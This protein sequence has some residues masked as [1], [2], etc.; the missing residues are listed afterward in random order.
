M[1]VGE[2]MGQQWGTMGKHGSKQE[3]GGGRS[4]FV[5]RYL[6]FGEFGVWQFN[7]W[8]IFIGDDGTHRSFQIP[9]C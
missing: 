9:Q 8:G 1:V 7:V 3:N 2:E 4:K 6:K 5:W